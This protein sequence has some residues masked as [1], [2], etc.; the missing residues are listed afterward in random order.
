MDE[1]WSKTDDLLSVNPDINMEALL[2]RA[3]EKGVG[4]ILWVVWKTLDDQ[5]DEALD[6]FEQWGVKGIKVDFMQRDDQWMV[7][8]YWRI[9]REAARRHL[10]VDFHG[11]YKPCGLRRAYPNV[12]TREGVR[13]LEHVKWSNHPTPEH[14]VTLPFI[15]MLA[16]PMDYTPGAMINAQEKDFRPIFNRPMSM[17]TRC[18]QLAMYVVF[19][20]PLQMLADSPSNYLKEDGC[21]DFLSHVPTVWDET[22]VLD[23][24]VADYVL[25]ARKH[26]EEW[27]VGAMTDWTLRELTVDFSFLNEGPYI[28]DMY[29]DGVN[30][31]R[32]GNDYERIVRTISRGDRMTIG[33]APGG[34]WAARITRTQEE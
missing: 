32:F 15:R 30:A 20:S 9:A 1:G 17:G 22:V 7:N 14:N 25:V 21:M 4:L 19:E 23:A 10:L 11:S 24:R 13:G 34:G 28:M 8:Y 31:D 27:Y 26:G 33:L 6:L 29:R 3:K 12:L 16:G 18:N 5:L 2:S